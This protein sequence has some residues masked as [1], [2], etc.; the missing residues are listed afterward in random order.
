MT[1]VE[2]REGAGGEGRVMC[3][4]I[5]EIDESRADAMGSMPC[6][7]RE[8]IVRCRDCKY[9]MEH[10]SKSILGT[11]IVTLTCSGPIQGAYSEVADVEPE[12][13]CSWASR[14]EDGQCRTLR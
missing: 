8:E 11:E 2:A 7:R 13:F 1:S 10:R 9:A 6:K 4:H 14:L 3:E 12:D 5:F